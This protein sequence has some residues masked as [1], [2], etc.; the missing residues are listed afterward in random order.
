MDPSSFLQ[1]RTRE[2]KIRRDRRGRWW[3]DGDPIDHPNLRTS[4]DGWVDVAED[5]RYCLSNDINW[6][7]ITLEGPPYFVRKVT[8]TSEGLSVTL[9]GDRVEPL[10][11][12]TL[13]QTRAGTLYCRVREGRC[14]A[15]FDTHA[16]SQLGER[17]G[18]DEEGV[19]VD[20]G[21][22][23]VHPPVEDHDSIDD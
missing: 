21:G 19:Y 3:N 8:P 5:G 6:A 22:V 20:V 15:V 18:E 17:M 1:G 12:A 10:D 23:R 13:R 16:A 4:F 14:V 9:S 11:P 2:T 7:Y